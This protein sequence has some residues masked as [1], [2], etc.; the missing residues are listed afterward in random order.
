M[1]VLLLSS[2]FPYPPHRGDRMTVYR[3]IR[4]LRP[5]HE[6]TLLSL[7]DGTE[8]PEAEREIAAMGVEVHTVRLPRWRSWVQAWIGLASSS[9]SQV[10]Y[11][12]SVRMRRLVR[13]MASSDDIGQVPQ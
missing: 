1:R 11:Y 7:V 12:R 2:R 3:L 13:R 9:P 8:V 10:S 5:A 4:S 6:V